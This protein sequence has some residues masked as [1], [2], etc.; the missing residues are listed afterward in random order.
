MMV[1]SVAAAVVEVSFSAADPSRIQF[2]DLVER[3]IVVSEVPRNSS[4]VDG[5][6][7]R[8]QLAKD[9]LDA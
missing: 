3:G 6:S 5:N 4:A 9:D 8:T 2:L 7:F 1:T